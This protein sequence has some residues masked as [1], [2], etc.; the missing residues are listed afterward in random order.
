M[1]RSAFYFLNPSYWTGK[2]GNKVKEGSVCSF[3]GSVPAL[4]SIIPDDEDVLEEENIVKRQA[5]QGEVDSNVAVQLHGLAKIFAGTTK[6][7][8]C[9]CE[10]KSP[11]HAIKV[12]YPLVY[13]KLTLAVFSVQT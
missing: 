4:D 12:F 8:C 5:M 6:M 7:G 13:E 9:K 10:R 3:T 11:F 1:A 2:S